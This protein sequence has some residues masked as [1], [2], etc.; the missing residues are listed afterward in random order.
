MN[1]ALAPFLGLLGLLAR[2][3]GW[4]RRCRTPTRFLQTVFVIN[5]ALL[6][7]NML[8][9][10]PLDGGQILQALLWFVLGRARSLMVATVIGFMG[11]RG[12][13]IVLAV[14]GRDVWLGILCVFILLNC[15]RGLLQARGL[16]RVAK[17]PRR[18]GFACPSCK[19]APILGPLWRCDK[20]LQPVRHL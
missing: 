20:C 13:L 6:F 9:I 5:C 17:L 14:L 12:F 4:E 10:Y 16:A 1:V 11:V 18:G 15:W 8:P 2:P 19:Q 3:P 7:F